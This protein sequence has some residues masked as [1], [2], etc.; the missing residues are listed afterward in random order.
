[1][2]VRIDMK[3]HYL[4]KMISQLTVIQSTYLM[5]YDNL[6]DDNSRSVVVSQSPERRYGIQTFQVSDN[7]RKITVTT[8]VALNG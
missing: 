1:M 8:F 7:C 3:S 2:S 6:L 5:L 4:F